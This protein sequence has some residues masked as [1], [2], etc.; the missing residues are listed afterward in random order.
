MKFTIV[1]AAGAAV[2]FGWSGAYASNAHD[3]A[4][5]RH[6]K[7]AK[8]VSWSPFLINHNTLSLSDRF[9]ATHPGRAGTIP[10]T[11]LE[12]THFDAWGYGTNLLSLEM[13]K[14]QRNDPASPCGNFHAPRGGCPAATEFTL[15]W[16][17]TL[18]FNQM[19]HTH[20]F[21]AGPLKNVSL[22]FGGDANTENTFAAPAKRVVVAG[23]EFTFALPYGGHVNASPLYYKEWNHNSFVTPAFATPG[24]PSGDTN[25]A[26]T[27][28]LEFN[29]AMPLGFLPPTIPLSISGYANFYGPKGTGVGLAAPKVPKTAV[30]FLSEQKLSLDVGKMIGGARQANK[31]N[32]W[33]AYRYWQNK[34]GLDHTKGTCIGASTG[35]CTEQSLVT[36]ISVMF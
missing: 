15:H 30:E 14:S 21:S 29:Y 13:L 6:A 25:F 33:I 7:A 20:G 16:R 1:A 35:S 17:S 11:I 24:I 31:F 36:G 23:L 3:P 32:V 4:S 18:G 5:H 34:F 9:T 22:E 12:F 27:Y 26:G 8:T 10:K 28:A 2:I 19:F